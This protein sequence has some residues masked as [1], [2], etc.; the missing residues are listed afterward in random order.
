MKK[1][2]N[3]FILQLLNFGTSPSPPG[4]Q[5]IDT[6]NDEMMVTQLDENIVTE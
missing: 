5:F 3:D 4:S 6:E 2:K 1:N